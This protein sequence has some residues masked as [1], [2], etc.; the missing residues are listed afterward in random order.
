QAG[1][2]ALYHPDRIRTP[3][4]LSGPRGSGQYQPITWKEAQQLLVTQ[5]QQQQG[6]PQ[7]IAL[8]TGRRNRGTMG[9]IVERF[10]AGLGTTNVI[11]YDPFDPA[12]VRKAMEL[13]TGVA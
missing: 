2:Q 5:L 11:S 1:V 3:L 8:L 13:I 6:T 4:K 7:A 12:P 9:A 10:A